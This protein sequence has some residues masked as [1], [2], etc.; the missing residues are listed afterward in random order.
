MGE[1][2]NEPLIQA[3]S[4]QTIIHVGTTPRGSNKRALMIAGITLLACL[5][6][7]GQALTA[8][9]VL[10]QKNDIKD[11]EHQANNLNKELNKGRSVAVAMKQHASM[12]SMKLMDDDSS[13]EK[14]STE[15]HTKDGSATK[16]QL[17]AAGRP[18]FPPQCDE[19]GN[20]K[21]QQCSGEMGICWC[22][23]SN[24]N[25]LKETVSSGPVVCGAKSG[26]GHK[27]ALSDSLLI[28]DV[29]Q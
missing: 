9:F 8:Y 19:D 6:I 21:L 24:G 5:L 4:E 12:N 1:P 11:L 22:L 23:D 20:Y 28:D 26:V 14:T 29:E 25:V 18:Q 15:V 16:C 10:G 17:E 2:L 3:P 27:M 7:A 13:D